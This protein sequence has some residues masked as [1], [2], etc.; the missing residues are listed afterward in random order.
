M[1][2]GAEIAEHIA[3]EGSNHTDEQGGG[4]DIAPALITV[5]YFGHAALQLFTDERYQPDA[6]HDA[7]GHDPGDGDILGSGKGGNLP[8]VRPMALSALV[9]AMVS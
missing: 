4:E 2:D 6:Q 8:K 5:F 1:E 7:D 9:A 3:E